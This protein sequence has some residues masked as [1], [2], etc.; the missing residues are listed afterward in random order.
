[1]KIFLKLISFKYLLKFQKKF[2]SLLK[3]LY[4]NFWNLQDLKKNLDKS[5]IKLLKFYLKLTKILN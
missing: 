3:K 4:V 2:E 1:M 5:S